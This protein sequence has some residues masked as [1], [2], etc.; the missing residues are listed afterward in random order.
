MRRRATAALILGML[1][2][3][4]A[5][6]W[7]AKVPPKYMAV[8]E[9]HHAACGNCHTRVEPGQRT[10]AHFEKALVRHRTRVKMTEAQWSLLVDYLSQTP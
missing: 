2:A 1:A 10:R 8:A 9:I 4:C 3:A 6:N 7:R 5:A